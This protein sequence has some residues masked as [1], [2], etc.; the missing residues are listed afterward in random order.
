MIFR[1]NLDVIQ[2]NDINNIVCFCPSGILN[3]DR[4][5]KIFENMVHEHNIF[6][7]KTI[8]ENISFE[9]LEH[10]MKLNIDRVRRIFII[11]LKI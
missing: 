11:Y 5:Q 3:I 2:I 10:V 7:L 1:Y 8:Y 6:T 9:T 4:E